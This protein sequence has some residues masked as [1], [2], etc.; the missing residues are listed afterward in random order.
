ME[1][2][3]N[4]AERAIRPGCKSD[5]KGGRGGGGKENCVEVS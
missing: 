5:P 4:E 1:R 3:P 2:E